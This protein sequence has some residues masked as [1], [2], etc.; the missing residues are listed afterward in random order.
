MS[1]LVIERCALALV[2]DLGRR[3]HMHEGIPWSGPMAPELFV[4]ANRAVGSSDGAAGIEVHGSLE[5]RALSSIVVA[6]EHAVVTELSEGERLSLPSDPEL[7][8]RYLAIRGGIDAPLVLGSRTTLPQVIGTALSRGVELG[9]GK[10]F[11]D[12][13][14]GPPMVDAPIALVLGPDMDCF[15]NGVSPLLE[16]AYEIAP[17]SNR[18]GTRLRGPSMVTRVGDARPSMPMVLGAIQVP[19]NGMP[20]VLGPD[21]PTVG[22][23]PVA[24]V[25]RHD[26]AGRFH[27]RPIGSRVRFVLQTKLR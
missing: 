17:A 21:H 18:T 15:P 10:L 12:A 1:A 8:V 5:I 25:I 11:G 26:H 22:G 19:P 20:I 24:A 3:G 4:R 2:V 6:D 14:I 9:A 16:H 23:Y 7:R 13:E 27:S